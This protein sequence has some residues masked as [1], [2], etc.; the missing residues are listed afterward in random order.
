MENI[1]RNFALLPLAALLA[2]LIASAPAVPAQS[3]SFVVSQ[4][5]KSVGKASF[6]FTAT[7]T[8]YDSTALVVINMKGLDYSLSKTER[9]S[10]ANHLRHV[11]L[12]A[13]VNGSAVNVSAAPDPVSGQ[14]PIL[15]DI[16][17]N[18]HTTT[19]SLP[20]HS[21]AVFLPDFDPGALETLLALAVA[22]N[23]R[24]LWAII[25]KKE[26]SVVPID[27][28]TH[29]DEQGSL[30]GNPVVVH[31]LVATIA[32]KETD[33]FSGPEN[34]LLQAEFPQIGYALVRTGFVLTPPAKSG[35]PPAQPSTVPP[36]DQNPP[37]PAQQNPAPPADQSTQQPQ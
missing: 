11:Q 8:G 37:P 10:T 34:Q 19:T 30:D 15:L 1:M 18:G 7:P 27:L 35:P 14:S 13:A 9:L 33:L 32:G 16:S 23:N 20:A 12:S 29:A 3:A 2:A 24:D 21:A 28:A 31:H 26:G 6:N 5:G 25:P 4:H 17:A 22:R 36:A